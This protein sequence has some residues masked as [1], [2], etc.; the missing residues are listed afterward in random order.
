MSLTSYQ[1]APPCNNGKER[2]ARSVGTVNGFFRP[3]EKGGFGVRVRLTAALLKP[4][5]GGGKSSPDG[6]SGFFGAPSRLHK[7]ISEAAVASKA[8]DE[9]VRVRDEFNE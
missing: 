4:R 2:N 5:S 7:A 6:K 8:E 3:R 1:A 9:A